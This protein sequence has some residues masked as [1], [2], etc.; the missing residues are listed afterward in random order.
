MK[1]PSALVGCTILC[2]SFFAASLAASTFTI[3]PN[4]IDSAGLTLA[5]GMPMNGGGTGLTPAVIIGQ[6]ELERPGKSIDDGGF[7]DAAHSSRDVVPNL[8]F[9]RTTS[10]STIANVLTSDHGEAVASI[11]IGKDMTVPN[12]NDPGN[13]VYPPTGVALGATLN[14]AAINFGTTPANWQTEAAVTTNN[15]V[16]ASISARALN[17]SFGMTLPAGGT[18]DG[19]QHLTQFIDWSASQE[20]FLLYVVAGNQ[21]NSI[22]IPKDNFN[23]LTVGRS[24]IDGGVYRRV[25]PGNTFTEDAVGDRTSIGLLA[26][27]DDID[28]T[29]LNFVFRPNGGGPHLLG[30]E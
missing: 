25:S 13:P 28:L 6:V 1:V 23:G 8:L 17:M 16:E 12:P 19:N 24:A 27:G 18:Y 14:A 2:E 5:N 3:G 10:D 22:P 15:L 30:A 20:L 11:M 29:G 21:G 4:G 7:D 9:V 26:P